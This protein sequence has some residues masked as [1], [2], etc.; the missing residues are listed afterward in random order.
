MTLD[1]S[2]WLGEVGIDSMQIDEYIGGEKIFDM[3][4][5]YINKLEKKIKELK[6]TKEVQY[7]ADRS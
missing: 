1:F 3:L 7:E 5:P 4:A 2:E 6:A